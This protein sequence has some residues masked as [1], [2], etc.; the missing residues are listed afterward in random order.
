MMCRVIFTNAAL[1]IFDSILYFD[2]VIL[3]FIINAP[4]FAVE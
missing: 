3:I 2:F 1:Q 4:R